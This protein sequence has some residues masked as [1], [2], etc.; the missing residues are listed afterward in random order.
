MSVN[1]VKFYF[2]KVEGKEKAFY[3]IPRPKKPFKLPSVLAEEEVMALINGIENLK[4]RTMV[5]A[6]YSAGLRVSEIIGLKIQNIDSKRMIIHIQGAKGKK[7]RMVPLSKKLLETLRVYYI[8]YKPK[9]FLFE[10]Q[11]GGAYSARSVQLIMSAA[12]NKVGIHKKGNVHMLRHSYATHLM[13]AGTDLRIIQELLGHNSIGTT[14]L[15]THVSKKEI[16][17]IESPL[18][19]LNW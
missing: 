11:F 17:K 4:H 12:K 7:D 1:A 3:D 14:M 8:E 13:E 16:G 19:K 10:G 5:M 9:E 15:Y 18:D 2:E 6:G